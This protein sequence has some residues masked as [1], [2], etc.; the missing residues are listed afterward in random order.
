MGHFGTISKVL[1]GRTGS[2]DEAR[3]LSQIAYQLVWG[4]QAES[5]WLKGA[6][7]DDNVKKDA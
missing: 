4:S 2:V 3:D 1:D 7:V 6:K 5:G